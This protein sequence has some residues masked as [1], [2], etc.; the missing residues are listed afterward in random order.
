MK[1]LKDRVRRKT[2]TQQIVKH[3]IYVSEDEIIDLLK[4]TFNEKDHEIDVSFDEYSGG[5]IRG[6]RIVLTKTESR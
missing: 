6:A 1:N 3:H 2:I 5:G 4:E